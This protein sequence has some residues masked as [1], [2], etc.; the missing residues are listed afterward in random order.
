MR[1]SERIAAQTP[2]EYHNNKKRP[3]DSIEENLNVFSTGCFD[4]ECLTEERC[5]RKA[6]QYRAQIEFIGKVQTC[7]VNF[8]IEG[9]KQLQIQYAKW[10]H[11]SNLEKIWGLRSDDHYPGNLLLCSIL[12]IQTID[13]FRSFMEI[14]KM[15]PWSTSMISGMDFNTRQ[16][17]LDDEDQVELDDRR[18]DMH[19]SFLNQMID[20]AEIDQQFIQE[21]IDWL[22][23]KGYYFSFGG[24]DGNMNTIAFQKIW[25]HKAWLQANPR[26]VRSNIIPESVQPFYK[27]TKYGGTNNFQ[28]SDEHL[29]NDETQAI[30]TEPLIR[31]DME[32]ALFDVVDNM[33]SHHSIL[34]RTKVI[35]EISQLDWFRLIKSFENRPQFDA[36]FIPQLWEVVNEPFIADAIIKIGGQ[37]SEGGNKLISWLIQQ[38]VKK[39]HTAFHNRIYTYVPSN[40]LFDYVD[41]GLNQ[42]SIISNNLTVNVLWGEFIKNPKQIIAMM[43]WLIKEQHCKVDSS[44]FAEI[45]EMYE[46]LYRCFNHKTMMYQERANVFYNN[47]KPVDEGLLFTIERSQQV[48]HLFVLM[49][50]IQNSCLEG[51][52]RTNTTDQVNNDTANFV[53][54]GLINMLSSWIYHFLISINATCMYRFVYKRNYTNQT[55]SMSTLNYALSSVGYGLIRA[56][57]HVISVHENQPMNVSEFM[58]QSALVKSRMDNY[59]EKFDAFCSKIKVY[60]LPNLHFAKEDSQKA[61][62]QYKEHFEIDFDAVVTRLIKK[63]RIQVSQCKPEV[64]MQSII[65]SVVLEC[66]IDDVVRRDIMH[67]PINTHAKR[68]FSCGDIVKQIMSYL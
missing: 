1:R 24:Y 49:I 38:I 37:W 42:T 28:L 58:D 30:P 43:I 64:M 14:L 56:A 65:Q 4:D 50:F 26:T 68:V 61:F 11:V 40:L 22:A 57:N 23:S 8:D 10:M 29:V 62:N 7:F 31:I 15:F 44:I 2:L 9:I 39:P 18:W 19:Q 12:K 20:F 63:I 53:S 16:T 54:N 32:K 48:Q 66:E 41:F 34:Y 33:D 47:S 46:Y 36:W 5:A 25:F 13:H 17:H 55:L 27:Y 67:V 35:P 3:I 59:W 60:W 45:K 21:S 6:S 52:D 51:V